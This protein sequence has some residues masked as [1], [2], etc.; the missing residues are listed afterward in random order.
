MPRRRFPTVAVFSELGEP[1]KVAVFSELGE[2]IK[3]AV[4][5]ELG[6]REKAKLSPRRPRRGRRL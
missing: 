6:E 5:S 4:F 1:I 2:R 3:V